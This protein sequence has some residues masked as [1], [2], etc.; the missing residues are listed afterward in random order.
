[1][2]AWMKMTQRLESSRDVDAIVAA[3]TSAFGFVFIHPFDD[4]NGRIHRFLVHHV[5][6]KMN[7]T[8]AGILFPVSAAMLRDRRAYDRVLQLFSSSI[9][10]FIDYRLDAKGG[11]VVN[12]DTAHLYRYFDATAQT[13]YLYRCIEE[14]IR[15]DLKEEIG[16]LA[17]FDSALRQ[18]LDIVDMPNRRAALLVQLILQNKGKISKGKRSFFSEISDEELQRIEQTVWRTWQEANE[19]APLSEENSRSTQV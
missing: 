18:A 9:M 5:L 1:M 3:A 19:P 17:I 13:E 4:G 6:A 2:D 15:R 16:F 14:T 12:S 10:E 11:M 8:P 7:F